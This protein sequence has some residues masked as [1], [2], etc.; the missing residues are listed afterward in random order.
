MKNILS[1]LFLCIIVTSAQA[2]E[3]KEY[4]QKN[5]ALPWFGQDRVLKILEESENPDDIYEAARQAE[6]QDPKKIPWSIASFARKIGSDL[7]K[8][9]QQ[10]K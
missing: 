9:D 7:R 8:I 1:L 6:E 10:I 5:S 4:T 2:V 3:I